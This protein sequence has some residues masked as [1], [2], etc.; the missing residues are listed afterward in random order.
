MHPESDQAPDPRGHPETTATRTPPTPSSCGDPQ[1]S[2]CLHVCSC[3]AAPP[4]GRG[5]LLLPGE[6]PREPPLLC[7]PLHLPGA[8]VS[9]GRERA[10][11]GEGK[12]L[13]PWPWGCT[14]GTCASLCSGVFSDG[15]FTYIVEPREMSRSQ[16]PPQV[17]PSRSPLTP[18]LRTCASPWLVPKA[19]APPPLVTS[20]LL[21]SSV[22]PALVPSLCA[23]SSNV[24]SVPQ[25]TS[26][27][28]PVSFAPISQGAPRS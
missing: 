1:P 15:N 2:S 14:V 9:M 10:G 22:T 8:A 11:A 7:R 25:V 27:Q 5:P 12:S 16:E 28:A 19:V 3:D 21:P 13:P 17:S 18:Q 24:P 26:H 23:L 4:G 6:A 20:A